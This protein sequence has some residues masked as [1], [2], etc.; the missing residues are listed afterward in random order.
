MT[1]TPS[2]SV[3]IQDQFVCSERARIVAKILAK[4]AEKKVIQSVKNPKKATR[5]EM[6]EMASWGVRKEEQ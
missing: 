1:Y 4:Y 6:K 3:L 2:E 5:K